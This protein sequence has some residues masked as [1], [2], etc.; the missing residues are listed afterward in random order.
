MPSVR[1]F[2]Y[3]MAALIAS[4]AFIAYFSWSRPLTGD[5]M[6]TV[7]Q[8]WNPETA[9]RGPQST[10]VLIATP[11]ATTLTLD[12]GTIAL[13]VG[14]LTGLTLLFALVTRYLIKPVVREEITTIMSGL[15]TKTQFDEYKESHHQLH[16]SENAK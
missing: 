8:A 6:A 9:T 12:D 15:V 1:H 13:I 14:V 5:E 10:S 4:A 2:L 7:N 11:V 16:E 3:I